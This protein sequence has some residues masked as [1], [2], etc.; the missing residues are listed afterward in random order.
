MRCVGL[1]WREPLPYSPVLG[2]LGGIVKSVLYI[3]VEGHKKPFAKI[4]DGKKQVIFSPVVIE[5]DHLTVHQKNDESGY[6]FTYSDNNKVERVWDSAKVEL[7]K[8]KGYK[9]SEKHRNY[10]A[11]RNMAY[12]DGFSIPLIILHV[13]ENHYLDSVP[14][15]YSK[16]DEVTIPVRSKEFELSIYFCSRVNEYIPSG[17]Y[18]VK[19]SIGTFGF[20]VK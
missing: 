13:D 16:L 7:A 20:G 1:V 4:I 10:I 14:E 15:K 8:R 17:L 2:E 6:V 18:T 9:N 12:L 19:T 5:G 11:N 3:D